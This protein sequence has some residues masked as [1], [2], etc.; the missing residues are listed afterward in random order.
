MERKDIPNKNLR[1]SLRFAILSDFDFEL[2]QKVSARTYLSLKRNWSN[3]FVKGEELTKERLIRHLEIGDMGS[4]R[5]G[6]MALEEL[7]KVV[8]F[9][10]ERDKETKNLKRKG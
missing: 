8:G 2:I 7:G 3:F 5:M 4:I 6:K 9:E 10:I 1:E